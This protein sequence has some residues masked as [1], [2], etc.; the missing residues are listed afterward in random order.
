MS[1][2]GT[3]I[4]PARHSTAVVQRSKPSPWFH[5]FSLALLAAVAWFGFHL[6]DTWTLSVVAGVSALGMLFA[7]LPEVA[8]FSLL[9]IKARMKEATAEAESAARDAYATAAQ[10]R[11][12][13]VVVGRVCGEVV[14]LT[15]IHGRYPI[16]KKFE[17]ANELADTL[18]GLGVSAE[19]ATATVSPI[20]WLVALQHGARVEDAM[21]KVAATRERTTAAEFEAA[22][23]SEDLKDFDTRRVEPPSRYRAFAA[24]SGLVSDE[25]EA[26]L[27]DYEHYQ[28]HGKLRRP[29]MWA[30]D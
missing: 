10:V 4:E 7:R 27:R 8:E 14:T 13:A 22:L 29:E 16:L 9:G 5:G 2:K 12:L 11:Q 23:D 25:V 24:Q 19:E 15:G 3:S 26:A 28:E 21:K 1:E 17:A 30:N 20:R 18:K 6:R